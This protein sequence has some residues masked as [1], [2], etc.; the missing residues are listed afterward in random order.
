M[1]YAKKLILALKSSDYGTVKIWINRVRGNLGLI[2]VAMIF[3]LFLDAAEWQWWYV[4]FLVVFFVVSIYDNDKGLT[5]EIEYMNKKNK[6]FMDMYNK[7]MDGTNKH[8]H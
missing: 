3:Y 4:P 2:Q 7:I 5:Q 8:K 6:L 1:Q